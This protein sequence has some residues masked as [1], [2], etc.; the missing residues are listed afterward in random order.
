M[1][2]KKNLLK[3]VIKQAPIKSVWNFTYSWDK[4][5]ELFEKVGVVKHDDGAV[6]VIIDE[7]TRS[8]LLGI[9]KENNLPDWIVHQKIA[10][11]SGK[12]LF[13]SYDHMVYSL[14]SLDFPHSENIIAKFAS[15]YLVELMD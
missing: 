14:L 5:E 1:L 9:V 4:I 15:T 12:I 10:N 6:S 11:S 7:Q 2:S 3:E 8:L 13:K